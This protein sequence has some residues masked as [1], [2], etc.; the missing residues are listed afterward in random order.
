MTTWQVSLPSRAA[1]E[2]SGIDRAQQLRIAGAIELLSKHPY[3]P[4]SVKLRGREAWRVRVGDFRIVY[5]VNQ[6]DIVV[7][8]IRI[9]HR[10]DAYPER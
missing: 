6:R 7:V 8:V 3:P 2:L 5:I 4:K 1:K 10:K 9:A